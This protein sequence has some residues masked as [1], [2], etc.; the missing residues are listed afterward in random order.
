MAEN[1]DYA[2]LRRDIR[3][4][5]DEMQRFREDFHGKDKEF[6]IGLAVLDT[7]FGQMAKEVSRSVAFKTSIV[8]SAIT[9]AV[10][11]LLSRV[12]F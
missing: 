5:K 10:G 12:F 3:E 11:L 6:S 8:V 4:L 2:A 9:S 1:S 7:K